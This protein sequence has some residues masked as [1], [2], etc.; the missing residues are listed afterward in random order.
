MKRW[1]RRTLRR[2]GVELPFT[3]IVCLEHVKSV[4]VAADGRT[5]VSIRRALVFLAPPLPGD[6]RD[7]VPLEPDA[8]P[9]SVI[10][11]SPDSVE[12]GRLRCK[13]GVQVY[14]LPREPIVPYAL[15]V[16]EYGWSSPGWYAEGAMYTELRC[17]TRTGVME[18]EIAT[19]GPIET[20]IGFKRPRWRRMT[21][22][23]SLVNHA[24]TESEWHQPARMSEDRYRATWQV[25]GPHIGDRYVGVVFGKNGVQQW[26][27]RLEATSLT[28][29]VRQFFEPLIPA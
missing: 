24:L 19:S 20:G 14:W 17:E 12:V 6:L 29:R 5:E 4:A 8:D 22:E 21:S 23:R 25:V 9:T 13:S 28:A 16:H 3:D 27:K 2:I 1:L 7:V 10:V 26:Q 11:T 18:L 15:Y